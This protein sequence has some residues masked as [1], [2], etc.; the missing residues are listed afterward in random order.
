MNVSNF[1]YDLPPRCIAQEPAKPRDSSKLMHLDRRSGRITHYV[2]RDIIQ[3]LDR[4]DLLV[5]NNTRVIP[6]RLLGRKSQTGGKVEILLLRRLASERWKALIRGRN[7]RAGMELC[8]NRSE[9]SCAVVERLGMGQY[10][11]QFDRAI[12]QRLAEIGEIPLPPYI[13]NQQDDLERYQTVYSAVE[14][15]AAAPTAGLH[16]TPQLLDR[17]RG[18]GVNLAYCTL[19][20]GLDTFQPVTADTVNA[21]TIHSEFATLDT[22]TAKL[23]NET[24]RDGKRVVAVGTTSARTLESAARCHEI[25]VD[26]RIDTATAHDGKPVV[27]PMNRDTDLFIYPGYRWQ[28]VDAM[29]TNFHLPRSTLLMMLSAF[30][31]R[32]TMLGAY[33]TAKE[34]NYR[35]YSFGDAMFIS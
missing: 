25:E 29:I 6:A 12:D 35:F 8:L 11:I 21:H 31:G 20:I 4:D 24:K 9:I 5:M 7:I 22:V 32:E 13:R 26:S 18:K 30:A 28:V 10:I 33:E 15:S 3:L 34:E 1:D 16:F 2:F 27:I 23:V 19:H 17:L 14:G